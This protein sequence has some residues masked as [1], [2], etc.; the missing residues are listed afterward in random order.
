MAFWRPPQCWRAVGLRRKRNSPGTGRQVQAKPCR[1][2]IPIRRPRPLRVRNSIRKSKTPPPSGTPL[3]LPTL[4]NR[5]RT[6]EPPSP[7]FV[8]SAQ[9]TADL[10]RVL[11]AWEQRNKEV[12]SFECS[13]TEWVYD[14]T[15]ANAKNPNDPIRTFSGVIKYAAPDKGLFKAEGQKAEDPKEQWICDGKTIFEYDWTK[16]QVTV[17]PLPPEAQGKA[18]ADGPLPFVFNSE[19]QKL[20]SRYFLHLIT[21]KD[22]QGEIWLEAYP[23]CQRDA[24]EFQRVQLIL[25]DKGM[26]PSAMQIFTP[27]GKERRTYKFDDVVI[28]DRFGWLKGD[29]F[30]AGTPLG[31]KRVVELPPPPVQANRVI[32]G[33]PR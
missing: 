33:N 29:P 5:R 24:A 30:Q 2:P 6:P 11:A 23:R 19:A 32:L 14:P 9:Q 22:V 1:R 25:Q 31:W 15:F 18:I 20:K 3:Q 27:G 10:D 4:E 28:N 12:H 17:Y 26:I 7:P 13:F 21:P 16:H 8:L